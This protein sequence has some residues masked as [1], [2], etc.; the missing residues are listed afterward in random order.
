MSPWVDATQVAGGGGGLGFGDQLWLASDHTPIKQGDRARSAGA[1]PAA[2]FVHFP[3]PGRHGF[4]EA[5]ITPARS[6]LQL[7]APLTQ[8]N[9]LSRTVHQIPPMQGTGGKGQ[10]ASQVLLLC[11]PPGPPTLV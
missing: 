3:Q 5:R 1:P 9:Q 11:R 8:E 2:K 6:D 10:A 4:W 7:L